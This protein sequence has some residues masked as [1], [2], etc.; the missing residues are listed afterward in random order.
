[1]M[2]SMLNVQYLL[3]H[4]GTDVESQREIISE[5]RN[6]AT[7]SLLARVYTAPNSLRTCAIA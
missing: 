3:A 5:G 6:A 2:L 7:I 1:M 4:K